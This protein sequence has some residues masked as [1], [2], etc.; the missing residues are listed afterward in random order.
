ME[1]FL[2]VILF[3]GL[4]F[5]SAIAHERDMYRN[6]KKYGDAK[7]WTCK[8][9]SSEMKEK[10]ARH[11]KRTFSDYLRTLFLKFIGNR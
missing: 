10:N 6:L 8:I 7:A 1:I 2:F 3:I 5:L 9:I 4:W 11:E